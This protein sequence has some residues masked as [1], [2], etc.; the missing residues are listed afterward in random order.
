MGAAPSNDSYYQSGEINAAGNNAPKAFRMYPNNFV[1]SSYVV[2]GSF[3]DRG[4][5]GY[6]WSSTAYDSG[7]AYYLVLNDARVLPGTVSYNKYGGRP[8]R[9]LVSSV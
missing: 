4:S 7:N 2:S 8:I 9:C 5:D 1:Y 6:Y 3:Y